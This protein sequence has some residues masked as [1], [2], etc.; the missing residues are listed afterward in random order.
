MNLAE[1]FPPSPELAQ[2]YS[3]HAPVMTMI[4]WYSRGITYARRSLAVRT[5]LGDVWGQGQSL[6]FY[7]VVL[8]AASR[9]RESL[10]R[11]EEAIHL[12]VRTG[13]QWEMNT[14][15]WHAAFA[16]Y[17]LGELDRAASISAQLHADALEIGDQTAA[18][19][20]LSGWSRATGGHLPESVV[21][22]E[23]ARRNEDV[24]T[25]TEV[26]L[27]EAIRLLAAGQA[28]EAVALLEMARRQVRQ[29]RLRQEYVA[30]V[31]PWLAT[32]LRQ[33]ME[34]LPPAAP[35]A[36]RLA[37]R[38]RRVAR[39]ACRQA[40]RYRNNLPHAL[41]EQ[42]LV[43]ATAGRGGRARRLVTRSIRVAQQQEAAAEV[44]ESRA[45]RG[46][47]G[48]VLGWPGTQSDLAAGH[49]P[50]ATLRSPAP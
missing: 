31:L 27:A 41:R 36:R 16:H 30:P 4:P 17:R 26:R 47:L 6:H 33:Q 2:A 35:A 5:E 37:A 44:A 23:L 11:C 20:A 38:R 49:G 3:E 7:G 18:G 28:S 15:I 10:A 24:H 32:A 14:A 21:A 39:A 34:S 25:A 46:R 43:A 12:L 13:D 48:L 45:A 19:I 40:R 50:R 22:A 29:A 8:Y 1:R 9:Y 42:A